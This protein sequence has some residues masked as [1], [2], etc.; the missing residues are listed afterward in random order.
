[1][2]SSRVDGAERLPNQRSELSADS[3]QK[4]KGSQEQ[5]GMATLTC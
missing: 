2:G 1:M 5:L 3:F 4:S